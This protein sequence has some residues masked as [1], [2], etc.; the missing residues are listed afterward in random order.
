MTRILP[1]QRWVI[2]LI[3]TLALP[4]SAQLRV[5]PVGD[6]ITAGALGGP[7]SPEHYRGGYRYFLERF[8]EGSEGGASGFEFKGSQT[9]SGDWGTIAAYA[10]RWSSP[11]KPLNHPYHSGYSGYS[12]AQI[13]TLVEADTIPVADSDLILLQI[14]TNNVQYGNTTPATPAEITS[15]KSDYEALLDAIL[16]KSNTV[17]VAVAKIP[18]VT[19]GYN[20]GNS[21]ANA[22]RIV[23]F[24]EQ[25]VAATQAAYAAAHPGRFLLVDNYAPL[26]P[27]NAN[28]DST[29]ATATNHH[30]Y[31]TGLGD[32]V[33]PYNAG[34]RK[35]AA[36]Y[37]RAIQVA[38][39][40]ADARLIT[41]LDDTDGNGIAGEDICLLGNGT[42]RTGMGSGG[43]T[44]VFDQPFV[45]ASADADKRAKYYIKLDLS[46][47]P[48]DWDDARLNLV[49]WGAPA[50]NPDWG[51][52]CDDAPAATT[53]RLYGIPNGH[54]D[55]T[56]QDITWANAPGNDPNENG[57]NGI[58]LGDLVV[59]AGSSTGDIIS[60]STPALRDFINHHR[61]G[62]GLVTFA[63]V[64]VDVDPG[65]RVSFQDS[66]FRDYAPPFLQLVRKPL[67]VLPVGDSITAGALG[68][69]NSAQHY[70]GGYRYFLERFLEGSGGGAGGFHFKGSINAP[71]QSSWGTVAA[72]A[73]Q[74]LYTPKPL[75]HPLHSGYSGYSIEQI[76]ANVTDN[77][78]PAAD[79][80]L[81]LLQIGTNNVQYNNSTPA[82][83]SEIAAWKSAYED[84]LDA[85][86]AKSAT[87]KVALAKIPPVT[88]GN[89]SVMAANAARIVPFNQQVVAV[90]HAAYSSAHPGRFTL[91][92]NFSPLDPLNFDADGTFVTPTNTH[93]YFTGFGDGVHPYNAGHRKIA[94]NF[95]RATRLAGGGRDALLITPFDDPDGD[96]AA[97][98]DITLLGNGTKRNGTGTGGGTEVF[99]QPFVM[100]STDPNARAKFYLKLDLSGL[101][102]NWDDARFNLVFWGAPASS[103]D[104]GNCCDDA[105]G[106][107]TLRLFG[108]PDGGDHWTEADITW[109]NAPG[110][111]PAG[112]GVN[113]I[114]LGDLVVGAGASSGDIISV[115]TPALRD[116]V[117]HHRGNDGVLTFAVAG[118]VEDPG[119]LVTFQD[120]DFR[121]YAP[122]FLQLTKYP[123]GAPETELRIVDYSFDFSA[124]LVPV[125]TL[126][127]TSG[128]GETYLVSASDDLKS[129]DEVL[130]P[131]ILGEAGQTTVQVPL[132]SGHDRLYL[133]VERQ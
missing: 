102:K 95:W 7:N 15:W 19:D 6:S 37:W 50:G 118:L 8:L 56:E 28:S 122:P 14:G 120:S 106:A 22:A 27:L 72:Y 92:D 112:N 119:F 98:E 89:S 49:F 75:N 55:W 63:V 103:P 59:P 105:P 20:I 44:E 84:L 82:T 86:L 108:I 43:G 76:T 39:G 5:L 101:P 77:T 97:G 110:N 65:F 33:H 42:K 131:N 35:I 80:D 66:D 52:C 70:R 111:D 133:R 114:P 93:D 96:G 107:I 53:L 69:P 13:T 57:A 45:L 3:L 115:S 125:A 58:P 4:A 41:P 132:P 90:V 91:V 99:D 60:V 87:V 26:D 64:G 11:P 31:F 62:D 88:N 129:F 29:F 121:D 30:D 124:P 12:I 68:G 10:G 23:P 73:G 127:F 9:A 78:I 1:L 116:F 51:N 85:I 130:L 67:R 128:V 81:I 2:L 16:A 54:D 126:T 25:V 21:G 83:P 24:N 109:A 79:A 18:P 74:W 117:N 113:G 46:G 38:G 71:D 100:S 48:R 123:P 47:L 32:G 34:H 40:S 94:A 104:W 36:N 17:K 61:G